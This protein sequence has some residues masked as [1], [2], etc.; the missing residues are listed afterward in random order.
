MPGSGLDIRLH[1]DTLRSIDSSTFSGSYQAVGS[2][3]PYPVRIVKFTNQS[4]VDVLVSWDG[5][6][7]NEIIPAS[8]FLLLDVSS[9][10]ET[11]NQC[12]IPAKTQFYVKGTASTGLFYISVYYAT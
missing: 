7:D 5:S 12:A 2:V 9:N 4:L 1:P 11:A 10:R 6:T 8:G 3:L